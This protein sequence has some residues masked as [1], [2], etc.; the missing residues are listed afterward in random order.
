MLPEAPDRFSTTTLPPSALASGSAMM[1]DVM[2]TLP[3]GREGRD[4]RDG[5]CR[6]TLRMERAGSGE[7]RP[8]GNHFTQRGGAH[9]GGGIWVRRRLVTVRL[10]ISGFY[11]LPNSTIVPER[12]QR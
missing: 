12:A 6:I 3:P 2:S 10:W 5:L 8:F 11:A 4:H 7:E 9:Y 1:R